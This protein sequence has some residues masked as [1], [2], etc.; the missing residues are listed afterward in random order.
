[1]ERDHT[2]ER[3]G[4]LAG[5]A[6]DGEPDIGAHDRAVIW[7][8]RVGRRLVAGRPF[9]SRVGAGLALSWPPVL[10][11]AAL[12]TLKAP[13]GLGFAVA[14]LLTTSLLVVAPLLISYY[15]FSGRESRR[16]GRA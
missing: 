13:W 4:E 15:L 6:V 2:D 16:S 7:M 10:L 12:Y 3:T 11:T 9:G 5:V 14:H 8:R 1:V